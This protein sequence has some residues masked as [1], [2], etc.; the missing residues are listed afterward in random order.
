[1]KSHG[2][3]AVYKAPVRIYLINSETFSKGNIVYELL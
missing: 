3:S 1:M 2:C